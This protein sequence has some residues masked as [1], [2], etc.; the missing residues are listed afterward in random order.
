MVNLS[1]AYHAHTHRKGFLACTASLTTLDHDLSK[2]DDELLFLFFQLP[3]T[4]KH[5]AIEY[6]RQQVDI[7]NKALEKNIE[8]KY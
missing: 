2:L 5:I 8:S 6:I 3:D 7:T 4:Q 1:E